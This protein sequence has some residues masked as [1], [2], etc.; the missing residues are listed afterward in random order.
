MPISVLS[1]LYDHVLLSFPHHY[2]Q[3]TTFQELRPCK[4]RHLLSQGFS[5][6]A[7]VVYPWE[8]SLPAEIEIAPAPTA[9]GHPGAASQAEEPLDTTTS[10]VTATPSPPPKL[11][12]TSSRVTTTFGYGILATRRSYLIG[13]RKLVRREHA[14]TLALK[15]TGAHLPPELVD[16]IAEAL[17]GLDAPVMQDKIDAKS[18]SFF[19]DPLQARRGLPA[20]REVQR[21]IVR[22]APMQC[23]LIKTRTRTN[24]FP[25]D[26]TGIVVNRMRRSD[27]ALDS[28][29]PYNAGRVLLR[30]ASTRVQL[31]IVPITSP[32]SI[33]GGSSTNDRI[34]PEYDNFRY[35]V[36]AIASNCRSPSSAGQDY[37]SADHA[38]YNRP[39]DLKDTDAE[40]WG[41]W[42]FLHLGYLDETVR[43]WDGE[44]AGKVVEML[45]LE[46]VKASRWVKEGEE[47]RPVLVCFQNFGVGIDGDELWESINRG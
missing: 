27:I 25:K 24:L 17:F 30:T 34:A 9:Q 37:H 36:E 4:M 35:G 38:T 33:F 3:L 8:K 46:I 23:T 39:V 18:E 40:S 26:A 22:L 11:Q 41:L 29:N 7:R 13:V 12:T 47:R 5:L 44:A 15:T 28:L 43:S 1:R 19:W 45:G 32:S 16:L 10:D 20:E 31:G 42:R 2:M 21:S 6:L 14:K